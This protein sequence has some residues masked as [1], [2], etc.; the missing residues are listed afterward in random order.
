[1]PRGSM[2]SDGGYL[3]LD[4]DSHDRALEDPIAAHYVRPYVGAKELIYSIQRWCLWL[5]KASG[6]EIVQSPFLAE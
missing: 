1:M 5:E 2:A 4:A 3:I 6:E